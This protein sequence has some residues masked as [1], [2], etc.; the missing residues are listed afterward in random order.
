MHI[1][2]LSPSAHGISVN[3]PN[4]ASAKLLPVMLIHVPYDGR[5][6]TCRG[7]AVP[8]RKEAAITLTTH[9]CLN[10]HCLYEGS[11]FI[12]FLLP[13]WKSL[14]GNIAACTHSQQESLTSAGNFGMR[15]RN[16]VLCVSFYL[17]TRK[18]IS[19]V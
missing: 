1:L 7:G 19:I 18:M 2:I 5:V 3:M 8:G 11:W 9:R 13:P 10:R 6:S 16:P 4:A 17:R 14:N 12:I 15:S